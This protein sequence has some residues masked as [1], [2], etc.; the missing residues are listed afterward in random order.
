MYVHIYIYTCITRVAEQRYRVNHSARF[1]GIRDVYCLA[2]G[3]QCG[4]GTIKRAIFNAN[5]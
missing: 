2:A 1:G 3:K 5:T 4:N